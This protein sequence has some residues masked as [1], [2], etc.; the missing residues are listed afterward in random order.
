MCLDSMRLVPRCWTLDVNK[1]IESVDV[2][3]YIESNVNKY[4]NNN[5]RDLLIRRHISRIILINNIFLSL[6][7][8]VAE[9]DTW[10]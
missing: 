9:V 3:K 10:L 8:I 5:K 1:Y 2:N 6:I 7:L 4:I